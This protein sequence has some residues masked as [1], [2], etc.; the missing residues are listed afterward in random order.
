MWEV[1]WWKQG[2]EVKTWTKTVSCMHHSKRF[3]TCLIHLCIS[4]SHLMGPKVTPYDPSTL[5]AFAFFCNTHGLSKFLCLWTNIPY[6]G[7]AR[8][9]LH[10]STQ[11]Q[12]RISALLTQGSLFLLPLLPLDF[13]ACRTCLHY[14]FYF[15]FLTLFIWTINRTCLSFLAYLSHAVFIMVASK[16][17]LQLSYNFFHPFPLK[18]RFLFLT[19][20]TTI[21]GI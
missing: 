1:I 12:L 14:G 4:I 21:H 20:F 11:Q 13:H 18:Y 7:F 3:F 17:Y 5:N 2:K 6:F 10:W 16:Y 15:Y 19:V 8:N 9:V